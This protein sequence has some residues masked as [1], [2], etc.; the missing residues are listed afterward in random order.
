MSRI[1]GL[2]NRTKIAAA[3]EGGRVGVVQPDGTSISIDGNGVISA[4]GGGGGYAPDMDTIDLTEDDKLRLKGATG[5]VKTDGDQTVGG[6]KTFS[7]SISVTGAASKLTLQA[8]TRTGELGECVKIGMGNNSSGLTPGAGGD[9]S[10]ILY[11]TGTGVTDYGLGVTANSLNIKSGSTTINHF[12]QDK[13]VCQ[14]TANGINNAVFLPQL[15]GTGV[16]SATTEIGIKP[17]KA[18]ASDTFGYEVRF[19]ATKVHQFGHN[20]GNTTTMYGRATNDNGSTWTGWTTF[21]NSDEN[22]WI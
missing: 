15:N 6:K 21:L 8:G 22:G 17:W 20:S 7:E 4:T 2:I 3:G 14:M 9:L 5:Y 18:A 11:G 19:S 13:N 10:L 1:N 16:V 12:I